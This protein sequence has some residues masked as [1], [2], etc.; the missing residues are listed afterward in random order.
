MEEIIEKGKIYDACQLGKQTIVSFKSKNIVSTSR[1]LELLHK[2]LFG[3]T[4][5]ISLGEKCYNFIIIDDYSHVT[6][7]FF[8][9]HKDETFHVFSKFY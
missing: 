4:R 3:P 9:A 8:L 1:P 5:T 6:W 2:N 7:I